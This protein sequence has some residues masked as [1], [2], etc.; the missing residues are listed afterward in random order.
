MLINIVI[1]IIKV[2]QSCKR[3]Q[4]AIMLINKTCDEKYKS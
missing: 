2:L 4:H 1:I 3:I